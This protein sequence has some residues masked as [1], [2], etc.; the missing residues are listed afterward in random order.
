MPSEKL[1]TL[2]PDKLSSGMFPS[3]EPA[4]GE[5][6]NS[7]R[8]VWFR[9]MSVEQVLGRSRITTLIGNRP[10][11]AMQQAFTSDGH[12]RLF[13]ED[14]G[15]I[16]YVQ[17][18]NPT[19]TNIGSLSASGD[20]DMEIWGDWLFVTDGTTAPTSTT[21]GLRYWPNSGSTLVVPGDVASQFNKVR[22]IKRL[23]QMIL[24]YNTDVLPTGFHWCT[25]NDPTVWTPSTTNSARNLNIRNLDSPIMAVCNLGAYH[26]VYSSNNLL[27]VQYLGPNQWFGTP[28]QALTGI[29]A[30]SKH[31]VVSVGQTNYGLNR[32]G[33][34]A[35]DGNSFYYIDRPAVDKWIQQNIDWTRASMIAGFY[36]DKLG[37]VVWGVPTIGGGFTTLAVDP[38][39]RQAT[40]ESL[41]LNRKAFTYLDNKVGFGLD[42][43]VFDNPIISQQDGLYLE[44][45]VNT[46][47]GDFYITTNL[48]DAGA[49]DL[50]KMWDYLIAPG[51]YGSD[52]QVSFGVTD[53]PDLSTIQWGPWVPL[54]VRVPMP[55]G[56]IESVYLALQFQATQN[57][58]M[59]T[60][61]VYGEKGGF[62][63]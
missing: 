36:N 56:P 39:V 9:E 35:T 14:V 30:V 55:G 31:S 11:Q 21:G 29:G 26:G 7:G 37:L 45:V 63:N 38:K 46:L 51:T 59:S 61:M 22:I 42:R 60:M 4:A 1:I 23:A 12:K 53:T 5:T 15:T 2:T 3:A 17:D 16:N 47:A 13:Y 40:A 32:A 50:Y 54:S 20:Y 57:F 25:A 10:S 41:Y 58:R 27:V 52:A 19:K 18:L 44:S 33:I 34:F 43:I 6:W 49:E 48:F 28:N 24:A 8:N 62:V